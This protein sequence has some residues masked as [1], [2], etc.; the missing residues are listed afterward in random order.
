ML[1][2]V[3]FF[4]REFDSPRLHHVLTPFSN[5]SGSRCDVSRK[6]RDMCRDS[7]N[8]DN[9]WFKNPAAA[10]V[11]KASDAAMGPPYLLLRQVER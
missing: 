11:G 4:G 9:P 10:S 3:G 8:Q 1:S 6:I 5:I 7:Q 2:V